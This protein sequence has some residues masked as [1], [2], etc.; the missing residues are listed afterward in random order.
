MANHYI[1]KETKDKLY[2]LMREKGVTSSDLCRVLN[3]A[4]PDLQATFDGKSPLY[5]K[6]Q[7]KIAETL[8]IDKDVLFK[9]DCLKYKP[10]CYDTCT[11]LLGECYGKDCLLYSHNELDDCVAEEYEAAISQARAD[12]RAK[13]IEDCKEVVFQYWKNETIPY[14]IAD[15]LYGDLEKLKEQK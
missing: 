6:W 5:N 7:K 9:G 15:K 14:W 4:Y 13:T 1:T 12:E 3:V 8:G 11:S 10:K 2:S